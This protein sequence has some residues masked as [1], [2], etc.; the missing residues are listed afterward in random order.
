MK[1][2]LIADDND[3]IRRSVRGMFESAGWTVC[4]EARNGQEAIE[5]AKQ[6]R[7]DL[8]IMD[9]SM[10]V[11]N[12]LT[13]GKILKSLMPEARLILF[14]SYGDVLNT[15]EVRSCGFSALISKNKATDLVTN[16]EVILHAA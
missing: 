5:N 16:A 4:G 2:I 7:P 14:T 3:L 9:L 1:S 8:V 15:D 12:G 13:A 10:P 6:L 11:M